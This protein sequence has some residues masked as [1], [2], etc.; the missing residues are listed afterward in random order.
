[1]SGE[2]RTSSGRPPGTH[3]LEAR[4]RFSVGRLELEVDLRSDAERIAIVG[5]SGAGKTTLLRILAGLVRPA[6]GVIRFGGRCW[7]DGATHR[8]AWERGVGWVPQEGLL[9][10]H[11]SV[12]ANLRW[13]GRAS[14]AEAKRVADWLEIGPLLDRRPRN[15]SGGERKRVALGRALL[16]KPRLLLLDEP[17]AALDLAMRD[18][19][20]TALREHCAAAGLPLVL[21]SHDSVDLHALDVER[22]HLER[23]VLRRQAGGRRARASDTSSP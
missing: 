17:F 20:A 2:A 11:R 7:L 9:F 8:P 15:L 16:S 18:R 13:A 23:G 22:W 10:P 12:H 21:V 5:P 14:D 1:M 6:D 4:V 3:V 19:I